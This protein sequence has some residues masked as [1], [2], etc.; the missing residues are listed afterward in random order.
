MV[1]EFP[2]G[3]RHYGV[4]LGGVVALHRRDA[5]ADW[6]DGQ[7]RQAVPQ[8]LGPHLHALHLHTSPEPRPEREGYDGVPGSRPCE[9]K[10]WAAYPRIRVHRI[11]TGFQRLSDRIGNFGTSAR[12]GAD[13][14]YSFGRS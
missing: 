8:D 9:L 5:K 6:H 1:E 14:G 12:P 10:G 13:A 2:A 3:L 4:D 7:G 11:R